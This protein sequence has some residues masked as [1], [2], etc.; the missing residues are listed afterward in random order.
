MSAPSPTRSGIVYSA[1]IKHALHRYLPIKI[2]KFNKYKHKKSN[3]ITNG[4]LKSI[5]FK[6]NLYKSLKMLTPDSLDYLNKKQNFI[7]Y[8]ALLSKCIREAKRLYYS[9]QLNIFKRDTSK[10]WDILK[11]IMKN[12]DR[13]PY[14]NFFN[15]N[16]AVTSNDNII[17][18]SFNEYFSNIGSNTSAILP[19]CATTSF[20]R[21]LG[22]KPTCSF[23]FSNTTPDEIASIIQKL[24]S[25]NSSGCDNLSLKI[26]KLLGP[27]IAP[28]ISL[29]VNQSLYT[30]IFPEILKVAK[31]IPIHKKG[32]KTKIENYRPISLLPS[33]SKIFEKVVHKQLY[34]YFDENKLFNDHQYGFRRQH[35]TEHAILELVDRILIQMDKGNSPIA[36]FLDLSAAFNSLDH[37][38]LLQKLKFYGITNSSLDWFTSYLE[39]RTQYVEF[40]NCSSKNTYLSTGVPQ[41]SILGPLLYI[42]YVN[43][44]QNASKYFNAI[45]YADDTSLINSPGLSLNSSI[46]NRELDNIYNW[47]STNKLSLNSSK[48]KYMLF[49]T[50]KKKSKI[51]DL[52]PVLNNKPIERVYEFKFLGITLDQHL[53][54]DPHIKNI[55]NKLSRNIGIISKLKHFVPFHTL[56]TLYC[57]LILPHFTYGILAWGNKTDKLL[58]IQKRAVRT[59]TLNKYN[60]HTEP[61]FKRLEILKI[62]DL[63]KL[64]ILKF[65]FKY[66]HSELPNFFQSFSL[67][68]RSLIHQYNTRIKTQL[69]VNKTKRKFA[70]N[71]VRNQI[72][73]I[74][75]KTQSNILDKIDTHSLEGY[76]NYIKY[77]YLNTY[78]ELCSIKNCYVCQ[79]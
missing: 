13:S 46:I 6:D 51:L 15:I 56:K 50:V 43:D 70:E 7:V 76:C 1:T 77:S 39:N 72:A 49:C 3:W 60:A 38:I 25:K 26:L 79:N 23:K 53:S 28:S 52:H 10:T 61:L 40:N 73:L 54:W 66:K 33:I 42:I 37:N 59:I 17:T 18:Q 48:T 31:V 30:G 62:H 74:V 71:C 4:L 34:D 22:T 19:D 12:S 5:K 21:Y 36:I 9:S 63:Y 68:P 20:H 67:Q 78:T 16:D 57:S 24:P 8:R 45:L 69:N 65:Y 29:I 2:K 75:N 32:D 11:S 64:N 41:G 55:A 44:I 27:I 14:P 47:F 58:K 35:S